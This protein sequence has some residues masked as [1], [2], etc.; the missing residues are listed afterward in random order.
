M[1]VAYTHAYIYVYIQ[2]NI[3]ISIYMYMHVCFK[4]IYTNIHI[5]IYVQ[6]TS[7]ICT[8]FSICLRMNATQLPSSKAKHV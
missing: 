4:N 8:L 6:S 5:Y 2:A 7:L 3:S 1:Y